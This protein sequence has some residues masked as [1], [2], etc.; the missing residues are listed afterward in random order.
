MERIYTMLES[1]LDKIVVLGGGG[2]GKSAI[3]LRYVQVSNIVCSV[4]NNDFRDY[5]GVLKIV[6][7]D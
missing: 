5:Y 6:N 4:V 2:V 1:L 7:C 3:T